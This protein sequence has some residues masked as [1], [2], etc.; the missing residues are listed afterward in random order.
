[1]K[2]W[3]Q[4][5]AERIMAANQAA[6]A[7]PPQARFDEIKEVVEEAGYSTNGRTLL[8]AVKAMAEDAAEK[9]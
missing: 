5:R 9:K 6:L 1:M 3:K 8:N 7:Q 4:Q 2:N